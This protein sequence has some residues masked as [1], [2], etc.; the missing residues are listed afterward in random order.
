[1]L[2]VD[3]N[4]KYHVLGHHKAITLLNLKLNYY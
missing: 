4:F 1:M 3:K 2:Y